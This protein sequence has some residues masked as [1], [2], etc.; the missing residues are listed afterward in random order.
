MAEPFSIALVNM[1]FCYLE[2]PSLALA[3]LKF[4]LAQNPALA[5]RVRVETHFLQH[6]F[7]RFVGLDL[8]QALA[9]S[10]GALAGEWLFAAGLSAPSRADP[11]AYLEANWRGPPEPLLRARER[12]GEFLSE[13]IE[14]R[15]LGQADLVGMTSL[16]QQTTPSLALAHALKALPAPPMVVMGGGNCEGAMGKALIR[17]FADL[18]FVFSGSGLVSFPQFIEQLLR[19]ELDACDRMDGVFSRRNLSPATWDAAASASR[20]PEG[21]LVLEPGA[22]DHPTGVPIVGLHGPERDI[23]DVVQ[24]DYHDFLDSFEASMLPLRPGWRPRLVLETSRGCWWGEKSH[25]TFCGSCGWDISYRSMRPAVAI[26]YIN[27]SI[28]RHE[29]RTD[30]FEFVD[31]LLPKDFPAEVMPHLEIGPG[32]GM[33]YEIRTVLPLESMKRLRDAGVIAVQPGVEALSTPLLKLMRKGVS[34]AHNVQHLKRC[35]ELGMTPMW[36]LLVGLPGEPA[37]YYDF[38]RRAIPRLTHLPPPMT[39]SPVEFHR[40]SPYSWYPKEHGLKL[41]PASAYSYIYDLQPSELAELAYHFQDA[42]PAPPYR[43]HVDKWLQVLGLMV[44]IWRRAW[45]GASGDVPQL[46]FDPHD[47]YRVVDTRNGR[48]T[49]HDLDEKS[50]EAL[51]AFQSPRPI[52]GAGLE[53]RHGPDATQAALQHLRA[54]GL[55]FEED[56]RGLSLVLDQPTP[57]APFLEL[58]RS[59]LVVLH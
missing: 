13:A 57:V 26:D 7:A 41:E 8:Y 39:V 40:N 21:A 3:Q 46:Y 16:Y 53:E 55:L 56:G 9:D 22:A 52:H 31:Q 59:Q 18:D 48:R 34:A 58:L 49:V 20:P 27:G 2:S 29:G 37:D 6:D 23:N 17:N 33:F 51:Q 50:L 32:K 38:Y 19:G 4:V 54:R 24:V 30:Y 1:P 12:V 36:A 5:G 35:A 45:V 11:A 15:G 47:R 10:E 42:A 28:A 25:C 14:R 43:A 44:T